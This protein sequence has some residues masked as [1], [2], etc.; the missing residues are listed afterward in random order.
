MEASEKEYVFRLGAGDL[1]ILS[2]ALGELP[3]K[4][5]APL[6]DK[7]NAQVAAQRPG[8]SSDSPAQ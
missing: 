4:M 8:G 1:Q 3:Y 2:A 6:V 5:A 7:L